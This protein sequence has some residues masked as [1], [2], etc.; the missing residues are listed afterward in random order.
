LLFWLIGVCIIGMLVPFVEQEICKALKAL[1]PEIDLVRTIRYSIPL[2]IIALVWFLRELSVEFCART[3]SKVPG[4]VAL[5]IVGFIVIKYF[6]PTWGHP[7]R[8]YDAWKAGLLIPEPPE[9]WDEVNKNIEAIKELVPKGEALFVVEGV[10][11]LVVRYSALRPVVYSFKDGGILGYSNHNKLIKWRS[12]FDN[13]RESYAK[14]DRIRAYYRM[15]RK[16]GA[17]YL[18][19]GWAPDSKD[20]QET[21]VRDKIEVLYHNKW[22]E[23]KTMLPMSMTLLKLNP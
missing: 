1:P 18:V 13:F 11:E 20:M 8:T 17:S 6:G 4:V 23:Y 3:K 9:A 16:R 21:S 2:T 19:V 14:Q 22:L 5:L 10:D 15:A 12:D 7:Q